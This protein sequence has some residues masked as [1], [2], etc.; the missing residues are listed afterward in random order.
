MTFYLSPIELQSRVTGEL[1]H[2]DGAHRYCRSAQGGQREERCR[3]QGCLARAAGRGQRNAGG[4]FENQ[5][6][7]ALVKLLYI[8]LQFHVK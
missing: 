8:S 4:C 1:Q 7:I 5:Y 3:H 2:R 6:A